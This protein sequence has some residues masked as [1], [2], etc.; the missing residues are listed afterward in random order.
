MWP[1]N[2]ARE[3]PM[4]VWRSSLTGVMGSEEGR[5]ES[6][7]R[8]NNGKHCRRSIV[9]CVGGRQRVCRSWWWTEAVSDCRNRRAQLLYSKLDCEYSP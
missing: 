1:R 7:S 4:L 5:T 3:W 6:K 9:Q 2:D 8:E